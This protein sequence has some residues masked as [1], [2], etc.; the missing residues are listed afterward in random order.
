VSV[1]TDAV[2]GFQKLALIEDKVERALTTA[3]D[4]RRHSAEN[5]ER[6]IWL[7]AHLTNLHR[8]QD[9]QRRLPPN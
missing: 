7:E 5:R 4:A 8:E 2:R 9:A 6:I 1:W 3:E